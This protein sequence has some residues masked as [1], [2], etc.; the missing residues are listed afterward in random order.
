MPG[1][2][3]TI[4]YSYNVALPCIERQRLIVSLNTALKSIQELQLILIHT[5]LFIFDELRKKGK[6]QDIAT[7]HNRHGRVQLLVVRV[8]LFLVEPVLVL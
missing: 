3:K 6:I 1:R 8:G 5:M 2:K 7:S 4:V